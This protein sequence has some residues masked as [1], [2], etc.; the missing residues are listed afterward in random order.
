MDEAP[1]TSVVAELMQCVFMAMPVCMFR[2]R[3]VIRSFGFILA[4]AGASSR[5]FTSFTGFDGLRV[6]SRSLSSRPTAW[7]EK[8]NDEP[9]RDRGADQAPILQMFVA[10]TLHPARAGLDPPWGD[11]M[12]HQVGS[13]V[14]HD[15]ELYN[16]LIEPYNAVLSFHQLVETLNRM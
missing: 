12:L 16:H 14:I 9:G 4:V 15:P 8:R 13:V 7:D 2:M 10:T 5:G 11:H 3:F 6:L 1:Q